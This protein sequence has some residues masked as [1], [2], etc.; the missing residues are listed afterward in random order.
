MFYYDADGNEVSLDKLCRTEPEWA[1][2]V[3]RQYVTKLEAVTKERD[4]WRERAT[5]LEAEK[6]GGA[7]Q[8]ANKKLDNEG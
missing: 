5:R 6:I 3:I 7:L 2:N 1:A 8:E 4:E